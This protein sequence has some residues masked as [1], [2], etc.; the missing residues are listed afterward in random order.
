[1]PPAPIAETSVSPGFD[2]DMAG[3]LAAL[4]QKMGEPPPVIDP[5]GL[6]NFSDGIA[7]MLPLTRFRAQTTVPSHLVEG[8]T[9]DEIEARLLAGLRD[10]PDVSDVPS[11]PEDHPSVTE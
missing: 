10:M 2:F 9:A 6:P 8:L 4:R 5:I 3:N 7:P 11:A 1:M